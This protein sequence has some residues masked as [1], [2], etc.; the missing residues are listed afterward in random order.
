MLAASIDADVTA[1]GV[2]LALTVENTGTDPVSL[3]FTDAQRVDFVAERPD[4]GTAV[5]RWSDDRMF[6]MATG[7]ET[8]APGESATYTGTWPDPPSG[9]FVVRAWVTATD[10]DADA[11]QRVAVP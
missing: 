4:D 2:E 7:S 6:G 11:A 8:L 10:V 1:D 9:S 5:W 3:S